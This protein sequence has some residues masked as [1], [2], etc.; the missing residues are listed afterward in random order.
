MIKEDRTAEILARFDI[1]ALNKM[2]VDAIRTISKE[3]EILLL[4]PT[5]S[6][7]TLAFLIPILAELVDTENKVQAL[8]IAPSREL[9]LQIEQVWKKMST[10]FKVNVC[11]GGHDID[12]E[13]RNLS[14]APALLISTPGRLVDH[15][16]RKTFDL[17]R[18]RTL[19]M[20]EFDKALALGF[21]EDMTIILQSLTG[22][23]KRVL[24][25]A[26]AAIEIP[27]F[28]GVAKPKVLDYVTDRIRTDSLQLRKVISPDKDKIETLY[29]LLCHI[30]AQTTLIFCN[31]RETVERVSQLLAEKGIENSFLHGGMEQIEREKTMIQFRNGSTTFLV[32]TDLAAR[33]L[34]IPDMKQVIHYHLPVTQ[35]EFTHRNGRTARMFG[36]GTAFLIIHSSERWP[37]Y[38]EEV[39]E[40][41]VPTAAGVPPRAPWV[42]LYISGGKKNKINKIDIVGFL[43]Q[44][45]QLGKEDIGLIEVKD[46]MS[47]AAI[48]KDKLDKTLKLINVEKMKGKKYKIEVAR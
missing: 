13:I 9:A 8:V 25:S 45:G 24:V 44:K 5:G 1:A 39:D 6:G 14:Q 46:F 33:G 10:G 47:F 17:S 31:H 23:K 28:A 19:V 43:S 27:D 42:T 38:L 34:D 2:Q 30:G 11:F 16:N 3:K 36:S 20:D 12:T 22:L 35:E 41:S 40:E 29:Q 18:I 48:K 15:I 4:S 21:H 7:K 32:A 37:S 26:T